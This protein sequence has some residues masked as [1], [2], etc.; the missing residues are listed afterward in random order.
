MD[1][2]EPFLDGG[3]EVTTDNFFTTVDLA[4]RLL[5]RDTTL[6]GTVRK[7]RTELPNIFT[8]YWRNFTREHRSVEYLYGSCDEKNKKEMMLVSYVDKPRKPVILLCTGEI[9]P[10]MGVSKSKKEKPRMVLQYNSTKGGVDTADWMIGKYSCQRST[11]RWTL[12]LFF[13]LL[14]VI[15]LNACIL[16]HSELGLQAR[17]DKLARRKFIYRLPNDMASAQRFARISA[18]RLKKTTVEAM[19]Q[20]GCKVPLD[21]STVTIDPEKPDKVR[22]DPVQKCG[23]CLKNFK[24]RKNTGVG[25]SWCHTPICAPCQVVWI[26][27]D[28]CFRTLILLPSGPEPDSGSEW[29]I[30]LTNWI[31]CCYGS[32]PISLSC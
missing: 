19:K 26:L 20:M 11:L 32:P 4:T 27:C 13:F 23:P 8:D 18:R 22:F 1:L 21:K 12:K 6:L 7:S 10:E 15:A 28:D 29:D 2:M 30:T 16:W 17:K 31:L 5:R 3:H 25:C 9:K 24:H 14:D